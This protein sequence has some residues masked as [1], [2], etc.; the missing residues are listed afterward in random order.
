MAR[1][2]TAIALLALILLGL[3]SQHASA[4]RPRALI[5]RAAQ[6][7]PLLPAPEQIQDVRY[8]CDPQAGREC[9]LRRFFG[10]LRVCALIVLKDGQVALERYRDEVIPKPKE[11][12]RKPGDGVCEE[13]ERTNNDET[14]L[15]GIAS[16]AKSITS[17]LLGAA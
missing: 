15:Y 7:A 11:A 12:A 13:E 3:P 1:F 4:A 8:L 17:T 10:R 9:D 16:V 14:R 6:P 5:E 2:G